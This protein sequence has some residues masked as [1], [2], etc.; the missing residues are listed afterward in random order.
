MLDDGLIRKVPF[1]DHN[2]S[3]CVQKDALNWVD[4][5]VLDG[6]FDCF[7]FDVY[8]HFNNN[9]RLLPLIN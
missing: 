1:A 6:G 8:I 9:S 2:K 5:L 7:I 3:V 4:G